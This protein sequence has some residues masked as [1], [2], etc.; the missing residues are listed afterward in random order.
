MGIF[1]VLGRMYYQAEILAVT[2]KR[3]GITPGNKR[4]TASIY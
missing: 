4:I 3:W 2:V 1:L